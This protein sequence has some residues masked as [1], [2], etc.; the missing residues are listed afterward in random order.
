MLLFFLILPLTLSNVV[1]IIY[2]TIKSFY[3]INRSEK[4][5]KE[6]EGTN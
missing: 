1:M 2:V 5:L 4:N 3:F 6:M